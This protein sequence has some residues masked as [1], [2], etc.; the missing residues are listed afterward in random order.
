M[1]EIE[2]PDGP[3]ELWR[4][5]VRSETSEKVLPGTPVLEFDISDDGR[6]VVYSVQPRDQPL[7]IWLAALDHASAPRS[8]TAS[9]EDWP[10]F[11]LS[12]RQSIFRLAGP[13]VDRRR[14]DCGEWYRWHI[15]GPARGRPPAADL[16]WLYGDL[17]A[18]REVSVR[19]YP[20]AVT[21]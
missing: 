1:N 18:R 13:P 11:G 2:S 17:G 5:N 3:T 4:V 15:R 6:E 21:E 19:F 12:D 7:Q 14:H 20:A 9:G 8:I 10:H 16:P